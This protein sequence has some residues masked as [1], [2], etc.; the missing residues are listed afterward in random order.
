MS[1]VHFDCSIR[2]GT[3]AAGLKFESD[4]FIRAGKATEAIK[5]FIFRRCI[6]RDML[7][8]KDVLIAVQCCFEAVIKCLSSAKS[9]LRFKIFSNSIF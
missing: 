5:C 7:R 6:L 4:C 9:L 2:P 8:Q 1:S 3:N